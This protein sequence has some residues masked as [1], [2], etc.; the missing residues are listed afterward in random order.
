MSAGNG[1]A[2]AAESALMRAMQTSSVRIGYAN[3]APFA[4][5]D[6]FS[7]QVT[8]EA[9][10]VA[11]VVLADMGIRHMVPVLTEFGALIPGLQAGRFDII[12]AGM[13]IL[14][15][16]CRQVRFS[17]PSYQADEALM[18][19]A[20]NPLRLHSYT[21]ILT[22][23][24]QMGVVAGTVEAHAAE[25]LGLA[26]ARTVIFPDNPSAVEGLIAGRVDAFAVNAPAARDL[27]RRAGD[28]R[29]ALAQPFQA[30]LPDGQV[31]RGYGAF[32]FRSGDGDFVAAFNR[33]LAHFIGSPAHLHLVQ[34]FGFSAGELPGPV[35]AASLCA[36]S[37]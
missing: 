22:R 13:Y 26:A 29:L 2:A 4:F 17:N 16:R 19:R 14:P 18:V 34:S 8:G 28:A 35:T 30:G 1:A 36:R 21:N 24:V 25:R 31:L 32:A 33:E 23:N 11:R 10:E 27:L 7:G 6:V 37:P 12:A 9:P 5:M 20:G 15:E 3:E